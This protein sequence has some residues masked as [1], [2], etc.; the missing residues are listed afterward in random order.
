MNEKE[1]N[2]KVNL[3]IAYNGK[4]ETSLEKILMNYDEEALCGIYYCITKKEINY[5]KTKMIKKVYKLLTDRAILTKIFDK[6]LYNEY[7]EIKRIL[8]D[9]GKLHDDYIK[10]RDYSFI[11]YTGIVHL[12]NDNDKVYAVIPED[13]INI[14]CDMDFNRY[15]L[16]SEEN[17]KI[18][19][20]AYSMV[21]LY[22]A[23][24]LY[25]FSNACC[26]Y[27]NYSDPNKINLYSVIDV[28]RFNSIRIIECYE[29]L[30][31]VKEEFL[32]NGNNY[33]ISKIIDRMNLENIKR[34][35]IKLED[36]LKY[37]DNTYFKPIPQSEMFSK[38]LRKKGLTKEKADMIVE[39]IIQTFRFYYLDLI[40]F[41]NDIFYEEDFIL[42]DNNIDDIMYHVNNIFNH[43]TVWG[44][45]GWT[46]IEIM[47][48]KNKQN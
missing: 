8:E 21:N 46:N 41:I 30:Y 23:V 14:I 4:T 18:N 39:T 44:N 48:G 43:S 42:D 28:E 5:N 31:M 22:G 26:K 17:T 47:L 13:I 3:E 32:E 36:L 2:K 29:K 1:L 34:K 15:K 12:F 25:D 10:L 37:K 16:I 19:D 9:G 40:D 35:D 24:N 20:L 6:L 11:R 45:N 33:V 27:Y 7:K 38:Y